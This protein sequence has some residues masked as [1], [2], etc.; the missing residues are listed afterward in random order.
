M[1][2]NGLVHTFQQSWTKCRMNLVR[3]IDHLFGNLVLGHIP[4]FAPLREICRPYPI[5]VLKFP[6][7]PWLSRRLP[8]PSPPS[9]A[10]QPESANA[11]Q[12]RG[13]RFWDNLKYELIVGDAERCSAA[14]YRAACARAE[15]AADRSEVDQGI[16]ARPEV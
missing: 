5:L 2:Q 9:P 7:N 8:T 4:S 16:D 11:Q 15:A 14:I 12:H 13:R 10:D 3:G 6:K 1:C